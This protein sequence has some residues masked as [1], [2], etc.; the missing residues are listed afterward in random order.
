ML[1]KRL[2]EA[3]H[4]YLTKKTQITEVLSAAKLDP[5]VLHVVNSKLDSVLETRNAVIRELQGSVA[6]IT[7]AHNDAARVLEAKLRDMGVP[8]E[9]AR[10]PLLP[11][12]TGVGPAGL[13][14][15]PTIS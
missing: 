4:E 3:E 6:T 7:K 15:R 11:S 8:V 10:Y 5:T 9:E 14:S 12:M 13:V 1:E 2:S